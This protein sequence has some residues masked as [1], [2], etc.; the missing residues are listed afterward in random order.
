VVPVLVLAFCTPS[1]GVADA[2][3]VDRPGVGVTV[4]ASV[5]QA[6]EGDRVTLTA[7][8]K[9]PATARRVTLLKWVVPQYVGSPSWEPAKSV[10]V[11]G[12]SK[13]GFGIVATG[14]NADRYKVSVTYDGER[15]AV[16]S[17]SL[18]LTIWRWIPLYSY[19]PYYAT[20][21]TDR[22]EYALN[23]HRYQ[24]WGAVWYSNGP[25]WEARFTP[26]R[27]CKAFQGVLGV[28]DGSDDG[29]SG[30]IAFTAD[31][32]PIYSSPPLTPGMELRVE[33]PLAKPYRFG[34]QLADTS[35]DKLESS[36]VIGD[37]AF[38][39]TGV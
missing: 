19:T 11:R 36:P 5:P 18:S 38:L 7:R 34:I 23:G 4:K 1:N 21:G 32:S 2:R 35:P 24:G 3:T 12:R 39:C 15:A 22:G 6:E 25:S 27:H 26:G 17:K 10:K 9:S 14:P 37:P 13:V 8:I 33:V 28:T 29:S 16:A 30:T 31:D 20:S